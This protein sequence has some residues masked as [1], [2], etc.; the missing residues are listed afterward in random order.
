MRRWLLALAVLWS[1][2]C[3]HVSKAGSAGFV[4]APAPL[5]AVCGPAATVRDADIVW[6]H[7]ERDTLA[8]LDSSC[9]T[10]ARERA[11]AGRGPCAPLLERLAD[12]RRRTVKDLDQVARA[13][14][15]GDFQAATRLSQRILS[16]RAAAEA[17]GAEACAGRSGAPAAG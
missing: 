6:T 5:P 2:S 16:I 11:D 1:A 17:T 8:L 3:A 9:R 7:D 15:A 12:W 4:P 13:R 10:A 14:E